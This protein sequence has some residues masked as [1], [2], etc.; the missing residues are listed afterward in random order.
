VPPD[1]SLPIAVFDSG[2]GGLTVLHEL[3]VSLPAED[4]LYLG[5]S[6]RF[7]YGTRTR[8]ELRERVAEISAFLLERGAKLLIVACNSATAAARSESRITAVWELCFSR[9]CRR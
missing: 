6:A 8:A 9:R 3:L 7:P 4:Y 5:D 1:R 2:V